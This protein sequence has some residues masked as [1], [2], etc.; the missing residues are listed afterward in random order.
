MQI[1]F[2]PDPSDDHYS[3]ADQSLSQ[4]M[5]TPIETQLGF[6]SQVSQLT[7]IEMFHRV[8]PSRDEWLNGSYL[9]HKNES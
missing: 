3:S 5:L 8:R 6:Q 2:G 7:L 9:L 1:F 4:P